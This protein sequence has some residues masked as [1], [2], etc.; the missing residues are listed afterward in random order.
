VH[1]YQCLLYPLRALTLLLGL[2]TAL[3]IFCVAV[4]LALPAL[5]RDVR[6]EGSWLIWACA[7]L[8]T[9]PL[10]I[11]GYLSGFL[12][13]VLTSAMAGETRRIRWPGRDVGL[14]LKSGAGWLVCFLAGPIVPAG[15]GLL[16]WIHGGDF[17]LLDWIILAEAGILA[18]ACW[19]LLLL[20]VNQNDRLSDASPVRVAGIIQHLGHRV[21]VLAVFA[22]VLGLLHGWLAI[23]ALAQTH[24]E[25]ALGFFLLFLCWTSAVYFAAFLFRWAGLWFY[26]DR[27]R[28]KH[29]PRPADATGAAVSLIIPSSK[30]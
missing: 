14:A 4:A 13:C 27:I 30:E 23:V 5:L 16:F 22:G 29:E 24:E 8:L 12:T 10:L 6:A 17:Q 28:E 21:V 20:A 9:I 15:A 2:S 25:L 19:F 1:G 11:F 3:T 26:W 18:I 7:T